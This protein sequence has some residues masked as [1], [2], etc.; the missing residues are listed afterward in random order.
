MVGEET[1]DHHISFIRCNLKAQVPGVAI[2]LIHFHP[3][4][5]N[6]KQL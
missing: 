2:K 6:L 5:K 3:F 4:I 1:M